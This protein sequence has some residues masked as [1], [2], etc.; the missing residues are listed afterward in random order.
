[1]IAEGQSDLTARKAAIREQARKNR[2]AQ[3]D[4]DA[5][6]A[7]IVR[8]FESLPEYAAAKTVMYYVD[9]RSEVRTRQALPAAIAGSKK[10]AVP[11]CVD[12][13]LRLFHLTRMEDLATGMYGILEP[14]DEL[15]DLPEKKVDVK[16]VDLIMVPGVAFD[17]RGARMGNGLG[18]YDKLLENAR[19][20]AALVAIAF[21]CQLFPEIPVG[22]HDIFM[23]KLVTEAGVYDCRGARR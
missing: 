8:T 14:R 15:R 1:M 10:I 3:P 4:K 11:Y 19:P 9:V 7:A 16:E 2:V 21:E 5:L 17:R 23:H 13:Y 20:D 22:E 18:Y 6:S 12:G